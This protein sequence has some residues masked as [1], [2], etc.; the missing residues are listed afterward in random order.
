VSTRVGGSGIVVEREVEL[1]TIWN[2]RRIALD[3]RAYTLYAYAQMYLGYPGSLEEF[4]SDCTIP[5][6]REGG[7][8]CSEATRGGL[9]QITANTHGNCNPLTPPTRHPIHHKSLVSGR[10][11][12]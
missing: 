11:P 7:R 5:F 1:E 12:S 3:S 2:V 10:T 4:V 9:R 6:F 8:G